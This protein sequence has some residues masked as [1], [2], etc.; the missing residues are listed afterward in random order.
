MTG[1]FL[2]SRAVSPGTLASAALAGTILF[3]LAACQAPGGGGGGGGGPAPGGGSSPTASECATV[4]SVPPPPSAPVTVLVVDDTRSGPEIAL[5]PSAVTVLG[6]QQKKHAQLVI[7]AVDGGGAN[8]ILVRQAALDPEP[9]NTSRQADAARAIAIACVPQWM[10]ARSAAP[11]RPGSDI[12]GAVDAAIR[13]APAQIIVLSDGLD[14]VAPLNFSK[15]GF[16]VDPGSLVASLR[17]TDS[18]DTARAGTPVLWAGLGVTATPVPGMVRTSL[19]RVWTAILSAART[20]VT[21]AP[22][23][24]QAGRPRPGAPEDPIRLPAVTTAAGRCDTRVTVPADLLFQ[25]GSARLQG[26]ASVLDRASQA[27]ASEPGSTAVVAGHTAAYGPAAYRHH[28]SVQRARA[29]ALALERRDIARRRL[30][31]VGFGS[32]QTAV[33]EFPDGRHDLAAAAANRRVV[34][35]VRRKGCTR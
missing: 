23:E 14:N 21:F 4:A 28:L 18:I 12:L 22:D 1:S 24:E 35:D 30:H 20:T 6:K 13:R 8:P 26:D 16:G 10:T 5:P 19:R 3:G 11:T 9:G 7:L 33:N 25:P 2:A 15:I 27:L 34:I 17:A 29:V 31:V 32:A